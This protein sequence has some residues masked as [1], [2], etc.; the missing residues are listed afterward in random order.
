METIKALEMVRHIRNADYME[1]KD[2]GREEL[3]CHFR[4]RAKSLNNE[5]TGLSRTNHKNHGVMAGNK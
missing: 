5:I 1:T 2:M 4:E 3:L